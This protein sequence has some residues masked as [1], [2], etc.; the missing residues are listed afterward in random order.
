MCKGDAKYV[1]TRV[2]HLSLFFAVSKNVASNVPFSKHTLQFIHCGTAV[3]LQIN[4]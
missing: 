3:N 1:R 2:V 4:F